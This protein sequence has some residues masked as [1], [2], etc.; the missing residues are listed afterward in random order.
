MTPHRPNGHDAFAPRPRSSSDQFN[1]ATRL[2]RWQCLV[3]GVTFFALSA[4]LLLI[5]PQRE[6]LRRMLRAVTRAPLPEAASDAA[7]FFTFTAARD[8]GKLDGIASYHILHN[9]E[10][11]D[12]VRPL[13]A[14]MTKHAESRL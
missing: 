8:G 10:Y 4:W 5:K 2:Q 11:A 1:V 14:P 6:L 9:A 12:L 3:Q 7:T 13:F